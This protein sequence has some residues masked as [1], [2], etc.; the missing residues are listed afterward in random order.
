MTML[1]LNLTF[2]PRR[3]LLVLIDIDAL[4]IILFCRDAI[5]TFGRRGLFYLSYGGLQVV[6]QACLHLTFVCL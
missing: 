1:L 3:L 2:D 4:I 5:Q 6:R